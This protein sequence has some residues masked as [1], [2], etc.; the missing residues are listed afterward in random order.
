MGMV[1]P[2]AQEAQGHLPRPLRGGERAEPHVTRGGQRTQTQRPK[3]HTAASGS[4]HTFM[5][6]QW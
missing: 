2:D 5:L 6:S 1:R 3:L 4:P